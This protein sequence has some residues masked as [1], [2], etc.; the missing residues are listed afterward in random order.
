MAKIIEHLKYAVEFALELVYP[1][2]CMFCGEVLDGS[3]ASKRYLTCEQCLEVLPAINYEE[4]SCY[5]LLSYEGQAEELIKQFKYHGRKRQAYS[6]GLI[7]AEYSSFSALKKVDASLPVPL[8]KKRVRQRGYNQA[9]VICKALA[10][11]CNIPI[12]TG[13]KR[14]KE[15]QALFGLYRAEAASRFVC[16]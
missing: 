2:L 4:N 8:H 7:M 9:E 6:A 11:E 5:C 13:L 10:A 16:F 15:T 12:L 3:R 14:V 1:E